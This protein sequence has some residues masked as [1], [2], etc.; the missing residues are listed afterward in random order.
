VSP[1]FKKVPVDESINRCP[2]I[3][4]EA[5]RLPIEVVRFPIEVVRVLQRQ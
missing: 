4:T 2:E 3:E 1:E 5:V